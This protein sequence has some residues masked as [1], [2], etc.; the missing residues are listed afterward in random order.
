MSSYSKFRIALNA[1]SLSEAISFM[2]LKNLLCFS[3]SKIFIRGSSE[4][5]MDTISMNFV[6]S[7][8]PFMCLFVTFIRTQ[9]FLVEYNAFPNSWNKI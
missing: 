2:G 1:Y 5:F 7:F 6:P 4:R 9:K 3:F 8:K